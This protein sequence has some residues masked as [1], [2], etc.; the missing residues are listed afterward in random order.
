MVGPG[1]MLKQKNPVLPIFIPG[2]EEKRERRIKKEKRK[3]RVKK[4]KR[5]RRVKNRNAEKKE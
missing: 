4:Q 2:G 1:K 5:K 3:R